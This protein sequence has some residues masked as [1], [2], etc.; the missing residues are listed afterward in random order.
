LAEGIEDPE[1]VGF[2]VA[3]DVEIPVVGADLKAPV[4]QSIPLVQDLGHFKGAGILSQG[5]EAERPFVRL[6]PGV[7]FDVELQRQ[8]GSLP[9]D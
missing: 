8:R 7:T 4:A 3:K 2:V 6:I 5:P 1:V 9:T